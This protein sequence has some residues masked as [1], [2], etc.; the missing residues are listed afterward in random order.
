MR[1]GQTL[2]HHFLERSAESFPDSVA[3]V[4]DDERRSYADMNRLANQLAHG[5]I[6][7]GVQPGDRVVLISENSPDY[8]FCYYGIL[9]AG[10][11][12]VALNTGL[13]PETIKGLLEE[14]RP[15]VLIISS[16]FEPILTSL[17]LSRLDIR[18]IYVANAR[19]TESSDPGGGALLPALLSSQSDNNPDLDIDPRTCAM[20]V[21]TSGSAGRPKGVM[22]T[23]ANIIANT[24]SIVEFLK[25]TSHDVQMVV[26]PFFYVMGKSLLN[27]HIAVGGRVVIHNKFA[28]T[29]SVLK[30]MAA[31][32]V[33]GFSGV[34]S[35]Y[36]HLLFKS[37][38]AC[39]RDKLPALRYCSQAGGHMPKYVKLE[40][41]RVLP[42]HTRL[43][44]MYG[45]TEA[46]ARLAYLAPEFLLK[47]ID[48]IGKPISG[49]TIKI[50]S[51]SGK[52][53][54]PGDTGELVAQG[55]NI[56]IGYFR[57]EEST[58]KVL[59]KHGYHTGDLGYFDEDGFLYV[60]GRKDD[61]LKVGG[62]R[63]NPQEIE[64]VI[65]ESGRVVECIVFGIPD[66]LAGHRLAGLVVPMRNTPGA[67][68]GM[69]DYCR[70]KLPN[71]KIPQTL[72]IVASIP[73]NDIGKP[74]RTGSIRFFQNMYNRGKES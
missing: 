17:H 2:I 44:I 7:A 40:L 28:Y 1:T 37:P 30:K 45:A 70:E 66:P 63:I 36:A 35:T 62:H 34:P 26:L 29:A 57:D 32:G 3:V 31:E 10:G 47:K 8:I 69:L 67:A 58:K 18:H 72:L 51:D 74:D 5:L 65:M 48:S 41:L 20:I 46:A 27:T 43:Y 42:P 22:L 60:T 23:H 11:I 61:Q 6:E 52:V 53:L 13:K 21:Y 55:E 73:K 19:R 49:V 54:K 39:F 9:K 15:K 71:Y 16:R 24:R 4:F 38:L 64:D 12:S 33:T 14:L 59:D 25:L 56:M 50:L 68:A